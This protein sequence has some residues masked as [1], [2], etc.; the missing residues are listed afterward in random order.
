MIASTSCLTKAQLRNYYRDWMPLN[1]MSL[2]GSFY[3]SRSQISIYPV[4]K[5]D[6]VN[7]AATRIRTK[8]MRRQGFAST[9][10]VLLL[11]FMIIISGVV[12][13]SL[14]YLILPLAF[15]SGSV[16]F[17]QLGTNPNNSSLLANVNNSNTSNSGNFNNVTL[18]R[19]ENPRFGSG[20]RYP[21]SWAGIQLRSDPS[22]QTNTSIVAI[23]EAPS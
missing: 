9:A 22:S 18:K 10:N 20:I 6:Y 19:Y 8:L 4:V 11:A 16:P 17:F 13:F 21:S 23:F 2:T 15:A 5:M 3:T 1:I 12:G 7:R 14:F